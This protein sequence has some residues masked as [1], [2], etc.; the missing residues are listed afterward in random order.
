MSQGDSRSAFG[1]GFPGDRF[2]ERKAHASGILVLASNRQVL[3]VNN[4]GRELLLQLNRAE[5][6][7]APDGYLPNALVALVDEVVALPPNRVED[8]S[9]RRLTATRL[10]GAP[11]QFLFVQAFA[12]PHDPHRPRPVIVLTMHRGDTPVQ[13]IE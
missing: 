5:K 13:S 7:G 11:G 4:A 12:R 2:A 9:W 1:G 3:Y 10:A 8:H 6:G